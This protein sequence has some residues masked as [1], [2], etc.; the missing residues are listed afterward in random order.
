MSLMDQALA[1]YAAHGAAL[2]PIPA[3]QKAPHGIVESFKHDHSTDPAAWAAWRIAHPGCNFGVVAFASQWI[4]ADTDIKPTADQTPEDARAEAWSMRAELF[5]SW[6]MP[7]DTLPHVNSARG[8]WHD[9]FA[10]SPHIDASTLRQPD[11]IRGRI[12]LRV[13]GYTVTAGSYYD[14]TA[15]GEQSGWYQLFANPSAPPHPAPQALLDHC[16]PP[17]PREASAH[18][19]THDFDDTKALYQWMAENGTIQ[20]DDDWRNA[21]MA[22]KIEFG[23]AG[24]EIWGTLATRAGGLTGESLNRWNSFDTEPSANA[25][26][27]A[28]VMKRAHDLGWKGTVRPSLSSMFGGVTQLSDSPSIAAGMP[29]PE[30]APL[31]QNPATEEDEHFPTPPGGFIK[32][33]AEF[34]HGFIAPDYLVDGILQRRYCYS[35]TAQTG[36]GKTTVAMRLAAHVAIGKSLGEIGVERGTVIYLA[37]ENPTDITMRILGLCKEMGLDPT[38]IDIHFIPGVLHLSKV[39]ERITREVIEKRLKPSLVVVDTAAAYFEDDNDN[40]NVQAGNH[41]RRLRSLCLLP[42]GPCVLVLCHPTKNATDD[43]LVPRGGGAFLAEVDGNIAL[44]REGDTIAAFALGK[45]RGPEFTPLNFGLK[46]IRDH[47]LLKDTRGRQIPTIIA[48]PISASEHERREDTSHSDELKILKT[49]CDHPGFGPVA[50]AKEL[51]W[52]N[53]SKISRMMPTLLKKGLVSNELGHWKATPKAQKALND[54]A[55]AAPA[56]K[57][58]LMPAVLGPAGV[59]LPARP[60]TAPPLP[61]GYAT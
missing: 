27:L 48:E 5:Q 23:D 59:P 16:A 24:L 53:H 3:G 37:G 39:A 7:P 55:N 44:R 30:G 51:G 57:V 56:P 19:G 21:G 1:F 58:A 42:G 60:V 11:A 33:S 40:D 12:N 41:A 18:V 28:S 34:V 9:Y 6:G 50:I 46:V 31:P 47:P 54:L 52:S 15:K 8:G 14:G 10:I 25:V 35:L 45:F 17:K 38:M 22:A 13:I 4:I 29:M 36:V 32:T 49:L 61:P 2:F 43:N 20:S 26:T